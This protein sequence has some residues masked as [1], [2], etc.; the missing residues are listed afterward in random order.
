MDTQDRKVVLYIATSVDGY[1]AREDG[2]IEWLHEVDELGEG[3]SG[4][5]DFYNR[6]DTV[7]MGRKTYDQVLTLVDDFPYPDKQCYVFSRSETRADIP[8]IHFVQEDVS[9]FLPQLT[10]QSGGDIWLVG[11]AELFQSLWRTGQVDELIITVIPVVLGN[12]IPLFAPAA[13]NQE[14]TVIQ[15]QA[16]ETGQPALRLLDT[17]RYGQFVQSHYEVIR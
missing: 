6:I 13:S 8:P 4:Y 1:I 11:G 17:T 14:Q 10:R 15:S 16:G 3:D 12:G 9:T 5:G 2:D 7:L